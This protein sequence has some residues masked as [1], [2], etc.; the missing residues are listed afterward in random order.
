MK[1]IY[2]IFLSFFTIFLANYAT[3]NS[4]KEFYIALKHTNTDILENTL[5]NISD[6]KH[7]SYG[8]YLTVEQ[9]NNIISVNY[10][11]TIIL[12]NWLDKNNITI[13]KNYTDGLKCSGNIFSINTAFNTNLQPSFSLKGFY[14]KNYQDYIYQDYIIPNEL[15]NTIV[16]IEGL[17]EPKHRTKIIYSQNKNNN[18]DSGY[19]GKEVIDRIYNI[20][21]LNNITNSS[22]CSI[23]YQSNG[24]YS[25]DDLL[26]AENINNVNNNTVS[27]IV[28]DN[29]G[30]DTESQLD[31]QMMGINV[32]NANIWF[33]D[34]DY[35][36]YSLAVDMVNSK[37]VPDV[38]SMSWGW[39]ED[40]Q[41]TVA[42]CNTTTSQEYVDRVNTEYVKLGLRGVTITTASGDAGAPGRTNEGCDIKRNITAIFPGSSPWIT[43]LGATYIL[44]SSAQVNWTTPLCINNTCATG[45]NQYVTNYN[46]TGWTSGGGVSRYNNR[47]SWQNKAVHKYLTSNV[48]LPTGIN[49]NGRF[50][51][52]VSA[53]GHNCPVIDG[54]FLEAVDGT[55]CSS[56]IFA[57]IISIL[58]DHQVKRGKPKLGFVNPIL[59]QM[60]DSNPEIFKDITVGNNWCTEQMCC[61]TKDS[62]GS[63]FGFQASKG[64]DPVYGLGTP[65]V[66]LMKEWLDKNTV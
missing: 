9:I 16:F 63:D 10:S 30:T 34:G 27:H 11:D 8:N 65:N 23:E 29:V 26:A 7:E 18:V 46:D 14:Y 52:D 54:G 61:D 13:I 55:S 56:P 48:S 6:Y 28:G 22:V 20:T 25:D 66:N 44:S 47:S 60:H 41:C 31:I 24:G 53:I 45:L 51:P 33:W 19:C 36:L 59:Y 1:N 39:A 17:S 32:P 37:S 43:S 21:N 3:L 58:N 5:I 50:Y 12:S 35:W 64:Y 4:E 62:G 15:R 38:V 49:K 2:L 42:N 57:S 40:Q